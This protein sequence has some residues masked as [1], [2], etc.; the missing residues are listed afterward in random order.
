MS[1]NRSD[2][3]R[4]RRPRLSLARAVAG[5]SVALLASAFTESVLVIVLV[6]FGAVCVTL[7]ALLR[8]ANAP[9]D[10]RA[11]LRRE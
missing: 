11:R 7:W 9:D 8:A 6:G 2:P 4:R 5:A 1:A 10:D 3:V